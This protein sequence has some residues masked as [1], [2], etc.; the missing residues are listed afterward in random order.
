LTIPKHCS[1]GFVGHSGA[2]KTT[3]VDVILGLLP[4]T[5]GDVLVDG[6]SIKDNLPAWQCRIGY[7][8]QSIYLSDDTIRRNI[9]FGLSDEQIDEDQIWSVLES[10]QLK[11]F[12]SSLPDKLGTFIGERGIRLSGGQ[13]QRIGIARA[14]YHNPE[15]LIMDE[16]T[17]SLDNETEWGI[18]QAVKNL[19]GKKTLIII[20]HR[21]GTVKNCD[22]LYFIRNGEVVDYGTYDELLDKSK[23]FRAMAVSIESK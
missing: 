18:M 6:K 11:E 12:V 23:E 20:A 1:T 2:G 14:L 5:F 15:V 4:P 16:G 13:R 7:I 22:R 10:A 17:A 19:S 21:L 9:A 3:I 8:P